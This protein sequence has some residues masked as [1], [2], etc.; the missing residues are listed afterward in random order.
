MPAAVVDAEFDHLPRAETIGR[1]S[2]S[3]TFDDLLCRLDKPKGLQA[4]LHTPD[5][6]GL[7]ARG[8][9]Y[10]AQHQAQ[11]GFVPQA[12]EPIVLEWLS[13]QERAVLMAVVD[14]VRGIGRALSKPAFAYL[15]E[16]GNL[17]VEAGWGSAAIRAEDTNT[18]G[19]V[20]GMVK[21]R[22]LGAD[23][24][25]ASIF[26]DGFCSC[27]EPALWIGSRA[28]HLIP[29]GRWTERAALREDYALGG[30][31]P[32]FLFQPSEDSLAKLNRKT[33]RDL[34][35]RQEISDGMPPAV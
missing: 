19:A 33:L 6:L 22:N 21:L 31:R 1:I 14:I 26:P 24:V 27:A 18:I 32:V 17:S 3:L 25:F 5:V 16:S 9:L 2:N 12:P 13:D 29:I 10:L 4:R 35:H 11:S 20:R 28:I 23:R 8:R 7:G 30:I 34:G 15:D